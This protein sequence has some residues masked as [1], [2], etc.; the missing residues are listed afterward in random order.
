VSPRLG[1]LTDRLAATTVLPKIPLSNVEKECQISLCGIVEADLEL[2]W[3]SCSAGFFR[4]RL[5]Q[6]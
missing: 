4:E 3:D 1:L 5:Y 6:P 2:F